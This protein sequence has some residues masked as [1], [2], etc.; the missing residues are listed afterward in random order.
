MSPDE[1]IDSIKR[2]TAKILQEDIADYET[3]LSNKGKKMSGGFASLL[4]HQKSR[5]EIISLKKEA[6]AKLNDNYKLHPVG[7]PY[8][9]D[10]YYLDIEDYKFLK[11]HEELR[12]VEKILDLANY[13]AYLYWYIKRLKKT[14]KNT[15]KKRALTPPIK[16]IIKVLKY[17]EHEHKA[18]SPLIKLLA[19]FEDDY[20]NDIVSY[21]DR[22]LYIV[23]KEAAQAAKTKPPQLNIDKLADLKDKYKQ[24]ITEFYNL[25]RHHNPRNYKKP[26][27][28]LLKELKLPHTPSE[29]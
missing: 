27:K 21:K 23:E 28:D 20:R 3:L 7:Y 14:Q 24:K 29:I 19:T 26:T 25:M 2:D 8:F 16:E 11:E 18:T 13:L 17:L 5:D 12:G 6:E 22:V 15:V 9:N 10:V 4:H 1:K